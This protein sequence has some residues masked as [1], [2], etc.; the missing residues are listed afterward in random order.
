MAQTVTRIDSVVA[1]G[2]YVQHVALNAAKVVA[3]EGDPEL[4]RIVQSCGLVSAD[5]QS[6]VWASRILGDPLPSRV[7]GIDLM[8]ELLALAERRSY[9][10]SIL[11]AR[12]DVLARATQRIRERHPRLAIAGTHDG[13]FSDADAEAVAVDIAAHR[14]HIVFVAMPS[15]RK[16]YLV[17]RYGRRL[18]APFVMG[19]GGSVDIL[20]GHVRRAPPALQRLGLEWLFRLA[21]EPRRLLGRYA[22]TNAK[23]A[24]LVLA[25]L[26]RGRR[27]RNGD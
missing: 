10:V 24:A 27:R 23:F 12:A 19:V 3:M 21:Q 17:G 9:R 22:R 14:P 15:P 8:Q 11:G 26:V 20:A 6:I 4:R 2:G 5:G 18:G 16:E 13:Y 7:A 1:H 25:E